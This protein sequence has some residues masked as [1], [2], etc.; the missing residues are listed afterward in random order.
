MPVHGI[1]PF[2]GGGTKRLLVCHIFTVFVLLLYPVRTSALSPP[3]TASSVAPDLFSHCIQ[4]CVNS[5][6][7]SDSMKYGGMSVSTV[8]N[9]FARSLFSRA[10]KD[11]QYCSP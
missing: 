10:V 8:G 5:T 4:K 9:I 7:T 6:L 3:R 11:G 1:S 2:G